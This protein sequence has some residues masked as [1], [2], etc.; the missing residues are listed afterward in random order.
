MSDSKPLDLLLKRVF[1]GL[2]VYY[3]Y[4]FN[5]Q[6]NEIML[7]SHLQLLME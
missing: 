3:G 5:W 7:V 6:Q 2:Q 1:H 4:A